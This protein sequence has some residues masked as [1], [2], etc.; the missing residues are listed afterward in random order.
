MFT[1]FQKAV[2]ATIAGSALLLAFVLAAKSPAAAAG[3]FAGSGVATLSVPANGGIA[4]GVITTGD[5][6]TKVRPDIAILSVGATVQAATA[7]EAQTRVAERVAKILAAAKALGVAEKDTKTAGYSISPQYSYRSGGEQAPRIVGYQ[8]VQTITLTLR[9]IEDAGKALDALVRNEGATNAGI[10]FTLADPKP[11]Q[12]EARRLAIEDA[13]A[14]AE[15][16]ARAAGIQ[17]GKVVSITD[18]SVS[19][20]YRGLEKLAGTQPVP[21]PDTQ[22]PVGDLEIVVNVQVQ[23]GIQ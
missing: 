13:K 10:V 3:P 23:F 15:A 4:P 19:P 11:A 7:E 21:A 1:A 17:L 5:G 8:A 2:L 9:K 20:S 14:K 6:T 16:M 22:I 12:A 18:Q